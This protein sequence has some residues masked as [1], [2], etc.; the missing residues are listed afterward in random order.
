MAFDSSHSFATYRIEICLDALFRHIEYYVKTCVIR[1][2]IYPYLLICLLY[3]FCFLVLLRGLVCT[4]TTGL[5]TK[6]NP[7]KIYHKTHR[8]Y[9]THAHIMWSD[10][11]FLSTPFSIFCCC[12]C[13]IYKMFIRL[14]SKSN[15]GCYRYIRFQLW[16]ILAWHVLCEYVCV[17]M[18]NEA[19]W[20]MLTAKIHL[21]ERNEQKTPVIYS[22]S[23]LERGEGGGLEIERKE[24][25]LNSNQKWALMELSEYK[26]GNLAKW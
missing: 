7:T 20:M 22:K 18:S 3:F 6:S 14:D 12:C 13:S 25:Y 21:K 11:C 2:F 5:L 16:P 15:C 4:I 24:F 26:N 10:D 8:I 23:L 17:C 19:V 1:Q 9:C